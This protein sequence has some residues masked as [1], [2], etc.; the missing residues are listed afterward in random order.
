MVNFLCCQE[1][2]VI[3]VALVCCWNR[4][5]LCSEREA[6]PTRRKW[7]EVIITVVKKSCVNRVSYKSLT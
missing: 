3:V 1:G 2:E 7:S 4:W 6:L 5:W